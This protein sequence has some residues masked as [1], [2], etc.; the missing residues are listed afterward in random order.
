MYIPSETAATG[1]II[2]W[3]PVGGAFEASPI[4]S[5]NI[6]ATVLPHIVGR[7]RR[8]RRRRPLDQI[9]IPADKV[10]LTDGL[11][12]KGTFRDREHRRLLLL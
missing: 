12:G 10:A 2:I 3:P 5:G 6:L 8:E 4:S 9:E 1:E 11:L 7:L